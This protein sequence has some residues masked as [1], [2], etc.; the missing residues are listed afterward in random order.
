LIFEREGDDV[1]RNFEYFIARGSLAPDK[2]KR[3]SINPLSPP[4]I[5]KA[6]FFC[7]VVLAGGVV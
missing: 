1:A 6:L 4:N 7:A 5:I 3:A 2:N